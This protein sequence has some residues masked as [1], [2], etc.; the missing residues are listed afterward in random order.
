MDPS[1]S[2]YN[3]PSFS[4]RLVT[5]NHWENLVTLLCLSRYPG[6]HSNNILTFFLA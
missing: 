2:L 3:F 1:E 6:Y 4:Q 5:A